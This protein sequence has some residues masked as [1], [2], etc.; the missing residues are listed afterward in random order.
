MLAVVAVGFSLIFNV[1]R[2]FH[3]A[4]G[5]LYILTVVLTT[6]FIH[7]GFFP[8]LA[9]GCAVGLAILLAIFIEKTAYWPLFR[10]NA[11]PEISLITSLGIYLILIHG[12]IF[13]RGDSPVGFD[14]WAETLFFQSNML[15][16]T[17]PQVWQLLA[18]GLAL[19]GVWLF[20][21]T[22]WNSHFQ[23]VADSPE[24]AERFGIS[25]PQTRF[26]AIAIGTTLA[27]FGGIIRALDVKIEPYEGL[28][29]T[30]A[31]S[32]A[33]M[34]GSARSLQGTVVACVVIAFTQNVADF[35]GLSAW[36]EALT[37]GMLFIVLLFFQ[38]GL[39]SQ[40]QRLDRP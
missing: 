19:T 27:A 6:I 18:S 38:E 9:V 10:A 39:F 13:F 34:I 37:F 35:F 20:T 5:G 26:L 16:M 24:I 8:V 33:V 4:H 36:K 25:V 28:G 3:L 29:I 21:K 15:R 12:L 17:F 11:R 30:L 22:K 1:A 32:V 2:V 40:N 7:A 23:A 14:N 31:A